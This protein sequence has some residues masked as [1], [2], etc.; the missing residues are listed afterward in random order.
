MLVCITVLELS[1]VAVKVGLF[2]KTAD[3]KPKTGVQD[4]FE[5]GYPVPGV[6]LV[7]APVPTVRKWILI[8]TAGELVF[9]WPRKKI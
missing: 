4:Q 1:L 2:L 5:Q 8:S 6:D 3:R 7:P 9:Q